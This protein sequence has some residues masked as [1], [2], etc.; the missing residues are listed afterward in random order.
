MLITR[1]P[2]L[3]RDQP[4]PWPMRP[5]C[6]EALTVG[7]VDLFDLTPSH[8][9]GFNFLG[10]EQIT[11][12]VP[13]NDAG[14]QRRNTEQ[15]LHLPAL[16]STRLSTGADEPDLCTTP[17][18]Q[19]QMHL[20]RLLLGVW[21]GHVC[22][23]PCCPK[24]KILAPFQYIL[25]SPAGSYWKMCVRPLSLSCVHGAW[26]SPLPPARPAF[27]KCIKCC[28]NL[29]CAVMAGSQAQ[30]EHSL[31]SSQTALTQTLHRFHRH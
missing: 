17:L 5:A 23:Q 29:F 19:S 2:L 28:L 7:G 21:S 27:S 1:L 20:L 22:M 11:V 8:A 6:P 31:G 24:G 12:A 16:P 18:V 13:G 15:S 3:R 25:C 30:K 10:F 26:L 4:N 14:L 9:A